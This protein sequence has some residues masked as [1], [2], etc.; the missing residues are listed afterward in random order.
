M[1]PL[2]INHDYLNQRKKLENLTILCQKSGKSLL[3]LSLATFELNFDSL[4]R[5]T[6]IYSWYDTTQKQPYKHT[7][8]RTDYI[9]FLKLGGS[10]RN[11]FLLALYI[12]LSISVWHNGYIYY[13]NR[14]TCPCLWNFI[15]FELG[16]AFIR[17]EPAKEQRGRD[18]LYTTTTGII[19]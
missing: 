2:P 9:N 17:L 12:Y 10:V 16:L 19:Y 6:R 1:I 15:C 13:N 11:L 8:H 4:I 7:F 3:F 5:I 18:F 14:H